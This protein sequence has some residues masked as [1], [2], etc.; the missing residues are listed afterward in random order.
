MLI[1]HFCICIALYFTVVQ[2]LGSFSKPGR[3]CKLIKDGASHSLQDGEYWIY[4]TGTG[5][6]FIA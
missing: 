5:I 4:P 1:K 2:I 6:P 3:S